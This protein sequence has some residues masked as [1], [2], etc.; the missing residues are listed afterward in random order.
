LRMSS[1][2]GD[3]LASSWIPA[4]LFAPNQRIKA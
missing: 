1:S 4:A 3:K 2:F